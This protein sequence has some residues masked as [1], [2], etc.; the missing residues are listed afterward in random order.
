[1]SLQITD[2]RRRSTGRTALSLAAV[3]SLAVPLAVAALPLRAAA[4]T[5]ELDAAPVRTRHMGALRELA[6][7]QPRSEGDQALVDGW[8]LYRTE[9]AQ[10]AFN[11]AMATL[12]STRGAPP[13]PDVFT[14][15]AGLD[16]NLSLPVMT[17]DGWIPAGRIWISPADY[18][19][20]VHSP[21]LPAGRSYRR[22]GA[23]S[24]KYFVFHE[25]H[26]S[27]RNTDTFDT[28]SSHSGSVF[29]PFYMSK[30]ATDANGRH[31]VIV[32]QVAP[33][34]VV[35]IHASNRGSAGPG[36]EVARNLSDPVDPLQN[37]AGIVVV[38]IVKAAAPHL[39]VV[40]HHGSEGLPMLQA[41]ERRVAVL[42]AAAR[43][44]TVTL[45]FVAAQDKR[46][47]TATARLGDLIVRPGVS[48]GLPV[49]ERGI[50]PP[51]APA[52]LLAGAG[53]PEPK[54]IG[55]IRLATRPAPDPATATRR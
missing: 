33:F 29:V 40:N 11:D 49:A 3:L 38:N 8:P 15:C 5:A 26:N 44:P 18:V 53:Q 46:L 24:L 50:A 45:P 7:K 21:R 12:Q 51:K 9:R 25:F 27:T 34:D 19:L 43:S 47:A 20:M 2:W 4:Q 35:S 31:F 17:R 13:A 30:R 41:Y 28:I 14:R 1:M 10:A 39:Q 55:P 16:C 36:I 6:Q 37:L 22:R 54:L 32:V 23:R 48:P 52:P 42:R